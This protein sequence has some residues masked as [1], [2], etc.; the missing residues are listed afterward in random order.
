MANKLPRPPEDRT[1]N[2]LH[3]H[4]TLPATPGSL[5]FLW[6]IVVLYYCRAATFPATFLSQLANRCFRGLWDH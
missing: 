3:A 4:G 1:Q 6:H 5:S 2:L